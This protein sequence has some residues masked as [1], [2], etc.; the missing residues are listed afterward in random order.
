[1]LSTVGAARQP[2]GMGR[3]AFSL[4]QAFSCFFPPVSVQQCPTRAGRDLALTLG[5]SLGCD[6]VKSGVSYEAA[7]AVPASTVRGNVCVCDPGTKPA[8]G[9]VRI[10]LT[11]F[12][13]W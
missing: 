1:M 4:T 3:V 2:A 13:A 8:C 9:S 6:G 11:I 12:F 7:A 10:K 5:S